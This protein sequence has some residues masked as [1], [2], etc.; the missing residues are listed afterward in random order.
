MSDFRRTKSVG[1]RLN[2]NKGGALSGQQ[3]HDL[4]GQ[5]HS[6]LELSGQDV[7][8]RTRRGQGDPGF[9]LLQQPKW[10]EEQILIKSIIG[11][12]NFLL[13]VACSREQQTR[14]FKTIHCQFINGKEKFIFVSSLFSPSPRKMLAKIY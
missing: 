7:Q 5:G 1:F 3:R 9:S 6:G 2:Q 8:S 14:K 13:S 11:L 4:S 12:E 10:I